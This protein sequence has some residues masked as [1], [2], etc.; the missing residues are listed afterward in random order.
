MCLNAVALKT[1]QNKT[2]KTRF[3]LSRL[4][5]F[6]ASFTGERERERWCVCVC[7]GGVERGPASG[8]T[9]ARIIIIS[10]A[11]NNPVFK[12]LKMIFGEF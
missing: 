10:D 6:A 11:F 4:Q 9:G 3:L 2:K 8:D 7:V 5:L 1:K 12:A